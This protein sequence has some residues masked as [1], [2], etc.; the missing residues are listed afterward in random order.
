MNIY[1]LYV[2]ELNKQKKNPSVRLP[3]C[4]SVCLCACTYVG[5][6]VSSVDTITFDGVCESK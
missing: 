6:W 1:D 5:T 2:L 3:V 4:L